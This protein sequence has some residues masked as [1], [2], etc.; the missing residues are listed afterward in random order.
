MK[1]RTL[2]SV[3]VLAGFAGVAASQDCS[4]QNWKACK[5]KPWV[6]GNSMDTP[7]GDKWWPHKLWGPN[8]EAGAT[9]WYTKPDVVMRA[10]AE[11]KQGKTDRLGRP[12][13][14]NQPG[15][16]G[17]QFVMRIIGTPTGGPIGSNMLVYHDEFVAT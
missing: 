2:V 7:I 9:N 6:I 17:R 1:L 10:L 16:G 13:T 11:A 5:G 15:F 3:F 8:D 4:P 12:Y 14:G